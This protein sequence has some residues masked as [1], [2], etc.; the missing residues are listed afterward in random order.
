MV[1]LNQ[2]GKSALNN[3]LNKQQFFERTRGIIWIKRSKWAQ[4]IFPLLVV[5]IYPRGQ[6][7]DSNEPFRRKR[8]NPAG[9][10][11]WLPMTK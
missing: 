3:F 8:Q 2:T 5:Y 11:I 4:S 10:K 9:Y 1:A 6:D 7:R